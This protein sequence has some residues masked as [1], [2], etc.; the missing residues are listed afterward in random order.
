LNEI[1]IAVFALLAGELGASIFFVALAGHDAALSAA[2]MNY[3]SDHFIA[4]VLSWGASAAALYFA[5]PNKWRQR[6]SMGTKLRVLVILWGVGVVID[7]GINAYLISNRQAENLFE[8]SVVAGLA[9]RLLVGA[10]CYWG[11]VALGG[12]IAARRRSHVTPPPRFGR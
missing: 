10:A 4:Y 11:V 9:T 2:R 6:Q 1:A 12:W 5:A 3:M 8:G 7:D